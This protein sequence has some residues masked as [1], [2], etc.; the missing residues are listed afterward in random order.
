VDGN[1][2]E[3]EWDSAAFYALDDPL[4]AGLYYGLD[5]ENL[6]LRV[7][8]NVDLTGH[9]LE[10]YLRVPD[11]DPAN[12]Y[13]VGNADTLIG[14]GARRVIQVVFED[15]TPQASLL[16]ADGKG[17][18]IPVEEGSTS[19]VAIQGT[20][21]EIAAPLALVSPAARASD[22]I[23]LRVVAAQEGTVTT[24]APVQG[25]ALV[26]LPD[27]GVSNVILTVDDPT[28]DDDGP[29]T[30]TYP[31]DAVF[32]PGAFDATQ[33]LVGS[34]ENDIIFQIAI[35]GPLVNDWGSP[36]GMGILAVDIYID[37]DGSANGMRILLPGRNLAVQSDFAWDYAIFAEGWESALYQ[38][39]PEG[40]VS[41]SESAL[42]ITS[43]PGQRRVTIRVPRALIEGDP[44][45]WAYA[46]IVAS[47]EG[48][49]SA[50]VLRIRDVEA[51]AQQ[52]RLGGGSGNSNAT[53]VIDVL[54]P[55]DASPTQA[56]LLST[57]PPSQEKVDTLTPDDFAQIPM[58]RPQ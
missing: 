9:N 55:A 6:L 46:T 32:R 39:T 26:T 33:F 47:Q 40:A 58:L 4:L 48:F 20:T 34:D 50:G 29:G 19:V 25:P 3:G 12:A 37:V 11:N 53:R 17:G 57:Y 31:M 22:N 2:A 28:E 51:E 7:D 27:E 5:A 1:A 10:F 35:R 43:N 36:N 24:L 54:L 15:G 16:V 38:A 52:W 21:L 13:P 45:E 44:A 18:W 30:Y 8:G 23:N 56:E 41:L 42:V 14:F 49:P